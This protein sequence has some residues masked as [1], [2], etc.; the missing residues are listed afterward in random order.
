MMKKKR[1]NSFILKG[2]L[3]IRSKEKQRK[4]TQEFYIKRL[5]PAACLWQS[6]AM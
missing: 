5:R 1:D 4:K 3:T 6:G 2:I